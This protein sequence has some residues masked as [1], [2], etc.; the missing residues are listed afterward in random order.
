MK[1]KYIKITITFI[2]FISFLLISF[3]SVAVEEVDLSV[4]LT[5]REKIPLAPESE[6]AV[7]LV[8][9]DPGAKESEFIIKEK[10]KKIE[11]GVP[12]N[13][14]LSLDRNLISEDKDY[15]LFS[16][17]KSGKYMIWSDSRKIKGAEILNTNEIN[18]ITKR[19]P[20]RLITFYCEQG[21]VQ[22]RYLD[23]FAQVIIF[24]K[25]YFLPRYRTASGVRY[26]NKEIS[27]WNKG[28]E[29]SVDY[30]DE[31][32][33]ADLISLDDLVKNDSGLKARGQEPPFK[34]ELEGNKLKINFGYLENEIIISRNNIDKIR[35]NNKLI[36]K[37]NTSFLDFEFIIFEEIHR[38]IMSGEI[39]PLKVIIKMNGQEFIGG[40]Y[41]KN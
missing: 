30:K 26:L 12:V 8:N 3:S 31:N 25:E 21:K 10:N 5:Y 32:F 35:E 15:N 27:V 40:G 24:D 13:F 14:T 18:I 33:K 39:Y 9:V 4:N 28:R 7:I 11:N 2:I 20:F 37:I 34:L 29:L 22:L 38:D 19:F 23:G 1:K 36:Y 16:V 6:T 41:L 17:I